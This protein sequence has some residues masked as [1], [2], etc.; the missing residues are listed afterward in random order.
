MLFSLTGAS[1]AGKSTV[2]GHLQD[3]D[4]GV[5]IRTV[6]FDSIGVPDDADTAW[7]HGAIEHW[8]QQAIEAESDGAHLLLCGQVP[9]GELLAAP[10][11]DR[12]DGIAVCMLHCSP[13]VREHRLLDRGED[14]AA[15]VHHNRFGEW[16]RAHTLDP[17]HAPE[18]IRVPSTVAM[19]WSRWDGIEAGDPRWRAAIVDT[20]SLYPDEVARIVE[21]WL[22][23]E[24]AEGSR[25]SRERA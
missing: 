16:F 23:R 11:A 10:S 17:A 21:Q 3:V 7:R 20:D 8:V 15:I 2:L 6:E 14:P 13:G 9:M 25:R 12:L 1:G 22:R 24:L 5:P 18:V 19:Q 4:W